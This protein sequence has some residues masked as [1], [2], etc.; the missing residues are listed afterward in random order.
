MKSNLIFLLLFLIGLQAISQNLVSG[1]ITN[2][3]GNPLANVSVTE[4]GTLNAV[5]TDSNGN[6]NITVS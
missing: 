4:N 6:F 1:H 5:K 3:F 2:K